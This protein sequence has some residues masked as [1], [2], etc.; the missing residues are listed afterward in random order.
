MYS[1]TRS[2]SLTSVFRAAVSIKADTGQ[3]F[4]DCEI[5]AA[6]ISAGW[7]AHMAKA[8]QLFLA[9]QTAG[10]ENRL[11]LLRNPRLVFANE[12]TGSLS[13]ASEPPVANIVTISQPNLVVTRL[14]SAD[15]DG[16][17][18]LEFRLTDIALASASG[19]TTAYNRIYLVANSA[20]V[21]YDS[22]PAQS[23]VGAAEPGVLHLNNGGAGTFDA[24]TDLYVLV[25]DGGAVVLDSDG[26]DRVFFDRTTII[27]NPVWNADVVMAAVALR[28]TASDETSLDVLTGSATAKISAEFRLVI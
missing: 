16:R 18:T 24:A 7:E 12:T 11:L 21:D 23:T 2:V 5:K 6:V 22:K 13:Q 1:V 19:A 10:Y 8:A 26:S 3:P 4:Y 20:I 25:S 9:P 28:N 14:D 17:A 27:T 15:T